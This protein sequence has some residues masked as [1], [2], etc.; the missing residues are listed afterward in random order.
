MPKPYLGGL[1]VEE[2]AL[3]SGILT[4]TLYWYISSYTVLRGSYTMLVY[5][6]G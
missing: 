5:D 2:T 3:T 6:S 1:T 4:Y